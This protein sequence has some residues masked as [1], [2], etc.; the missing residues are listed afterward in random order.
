MREIAGLLVSIH[1]QNDNQALLKKESQARILDGV[2]DFGDRLDRYKASYSAL[3]KAREELSKR[4][5]DGAEANRLRDILSFQIGE[6]DAAHL[7]A[8]EEEALLEHRAKLQN[9]EKIAKQTEF[10]YR[11]LYGSEKGS[12]ALI[13][14][15]ASQANHSWKFSICI[16]YKFSKDLVCEVST[17]CELECT[18]ATLVACLENCLC[19]LEISVIEDRNH[20]CL[21]HRCYYLLFCIFCHFY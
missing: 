7:K 10:T 17:V 20:S 13:L 9:A 12:A 5:R 2:A 6:I 8:G 4:R 19:S 14:E 11:V 1:G 18:H 21:L 16:F 3:R 15:R